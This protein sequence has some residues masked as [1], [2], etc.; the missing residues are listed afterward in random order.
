M[1]YHCGNDLISTMGTRLF[2]MGNNDIPQWKHIDY[3]WINLRSIM[4]TKWEF[5]CELMECHSGNDLKSTMGTD[6]F[7]M[8]NN[9]IPQWK[10]IVYK[11]INLRSIMGTKWKSSWEFMK[12]HCGNNLISTMETRLFEMGNN[13]IPQRKYIVFCL[14]SIMVKRL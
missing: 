5:S 10:C 13:K 6:L 9:D 8:G 1:K 3:N 11:G 2:E 14:N 12:C 4:G 7:E